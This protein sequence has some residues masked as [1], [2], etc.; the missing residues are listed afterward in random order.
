MRSNEGERDAVQPSLHR[1]LACCTLPH[2]GRRPTRVPIGPVLAIVQRA[3]ARWLAKQAGVKPDAAQCGAVTLIQRFGSALNL[4]IHFHMLWIDGVYEARPFRVFW[5][6]L[7]HADQAEGAKLALGGARVVPVEGGC[8][9][10]PTV[11]DDVRLEHAIALKT[12]K[13]QISYTHPSGGQVPALTMSSY[14]A[15]MPLS[16]GA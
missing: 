16:S 14:Q 7:V 12:A 3:I 5:P 9:V 13:R 11:F 4:N 15:R 2:Q 8:Y 6:G 1:R 10:E